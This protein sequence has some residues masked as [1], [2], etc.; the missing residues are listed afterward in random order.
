MTST[1]LALPLL[2]ACVGDVGEGKVAA[3]VA[4]APPAEETAKKEEAPAKAAGTELA[5]DTTKSTVKALGAK[6]TAKHPID[7]HKW[8][9]TATVDGK[10]LTDLKFE[11]DMASLESDHPKLTGH[12][13][14]EDFFWIEKYPTATFDMAELK[15]GA[16]GEGNTHTMSGDLTI[17]GKTKRVTFPAKISAGPKGVSASTEFV[18]D[19]KDFDV[20]YKGKADDLVQDNVVL[21]INIMAPAKG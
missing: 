14:D 1:L 18:I 8:S 16:E 20:V 6:V 17:R 15:D 19:R 4:D 13:K 5:I 7:F 2:F 9:G 10:Q 12:L 3:E 11:I 21:T